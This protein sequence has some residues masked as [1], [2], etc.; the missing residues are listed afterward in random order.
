[1]AAERKSPS[2][3]A[4]RVLSQPEEILVVWGGDK[5]LEGRLQRRQG[6]AVAPLVN[7]GVAIGKR[8]SAGAVVIAGGEIDQL[9]HCFVDGK[10]TLIKGVGPP[11]QENHRVGRPRWKNVAG[12]AE[13]TA[14]PLSS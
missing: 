5:F 7:L 1:M 3:L 9:F 12:P 14:L 6:A 11:L 4:G 2:V 10:I 13:I 8:D